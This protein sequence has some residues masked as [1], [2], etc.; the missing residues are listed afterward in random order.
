M[1]QHD[2]NGGKP[3]T[4]Q[5][6]KYPS[7]RGNPNIAKYGFKKGQSG[8]PGGR[9]ALKPLTDAVRRIMK[10]PEK[11]DKLAHAV[12]MKASK[13][14]IPAARLIWEYL[15]GKPQENISFDG[16]M[17]Y[18]EIE[19]RLLLEATKDNPEIGKEIAN[20]IKQT[21]TAGDGT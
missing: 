18:T 19:I 2:S 1:D 21:I 20:R 6:N 5:I 14:N 15:E 3:K 12:Y 13:G 4:A 17:R 7:G 8:N 11:A 10:E 9:P 16:D